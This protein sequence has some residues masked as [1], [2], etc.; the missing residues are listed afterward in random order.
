MNQTDRKT[1]NYINKCYNEYNR[2]RHKLLHF[3][4]L[5]IDDTATLTKEESQKVIIKTIELI[6][7]YYQ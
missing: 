2:I 7:K 3:G 5:D 6:A 4:D 1:V